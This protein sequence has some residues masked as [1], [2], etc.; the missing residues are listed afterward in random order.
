MLRFINSTILLPACMLLL[1]SCT[2]LQ[3]QDSSAL[4][5]VAQKNAVWR[6]DLQKTKR[7]LY[8]QLQLNAK[9]YEINEDMGNIAYNLGSP[10]N[11]ELSDQSVRFIC[12]N[13]KIAEIRFFEM[14]DYKLRINTTNSNIQNGM[15][16]T[17]YKL[18]MGSTIISVRNE[19]QMM[20]K[21][22]MNQLTKIQMLT[23]DL[24]FNMHG[25]EQMAIAY[26]SSPAKP[27]AS[28]EQR[29]NI[30][31]ADAY[32][33]LYQYEKA[34]SLLRKVIA[35][36]ATAYPSAYLNIAILFAE[37]NKLYSAI[38][39]MKKFLLL[40]PN[41]ADEQFAKQRISE[42]EIMLQN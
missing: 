13:N 31:Q 14:S 2:V 35:I 11:I 37:T 7:E 21:S 32:A 27:V 36:D 38:Y 26:K 28:E 9:W 12:N 19:R 18:K 40:N 34:I 29:K 22:I 30:I 33:K 16:I 4:K 17:E 10:L 24:S 20:L 3:A 1:T 41:L 39:N 42:W 25:F 6:N 23:N 8:Y 15:S 5:A